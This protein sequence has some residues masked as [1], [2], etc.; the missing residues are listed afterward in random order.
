MGRKVADGRSVKVTVPESTT[1]EQGKFYLLDGFLG[2]AVQ[3]VTTGA[4]QTSA[5]ILVI[6]KGEYETS[7]IN[8]VD[9]FAQ[10]A[11]VYYDSANKRFTTTSTDN[12]FAGRVSVAKDTGNVIWF[13]F[14]PENQ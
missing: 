8:T 1:I 6:E 13:I 14:A 5:V 4:G 10:G 12:K 11:A 7:Q 2:I 3:S 9:A